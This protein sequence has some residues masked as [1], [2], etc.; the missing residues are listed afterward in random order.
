VTTLSF[1]RA[2]TPP[3]TVTPCDGRGRDWSAM[4]AELRGFSTASDVGAYVLQCGV[5][6]GGSTPTR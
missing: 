5:C 3:L 1:E 2:F 4:S 6:G